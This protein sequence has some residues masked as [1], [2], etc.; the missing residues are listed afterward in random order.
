M[1]GYMSI[2]LN[3]LEKGRGEYLV[4]LHGNGQSYTY[5][6]NQ[7]EYFSRF[8]HVI[9]IDTRGHGGSPRGTAPFSL[10]QFAEDLHSLI[11][12]KEIVK[13][14]ILGFSDGG[15]IAVYYALEHPEYVSRLV[16]NSA[17]LNP[18]GLKRRVLLPAGIGYYFFKAFS[19]F[20]DRIKKKCELLNLIVNEPDIDCEDLRLLKMPVLVIAGTHDMITRKHTEL[21]SRCINDSKLCFIRGNHFIAAKRPDEFNRIVHEFLSCLE[22]N[23]SNKSKST[24]LS[25]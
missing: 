4:L 18:D 5:F 8:Y 16:L 1:R 10:K 24:F 7:I 15:N 3:Y 11:L 19:G 20:S 14:N 25:A 2:G 22:K 21:I 23:S 13:T 9:A 17:N 12:K 6:Q